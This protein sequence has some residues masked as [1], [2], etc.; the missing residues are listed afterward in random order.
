MSIDDG[1][2][3]GAA[4]ARRV[5]L[6]RWLSSVLL[7]LAGS[8]ATALHALEEGAATRTVET[9]HAALA[10]NIADGAAL[11]LE[12]RLAR[13]EPVLAEVFDFQTIAMVALGDAYA[14]LD[15]SQQARFRALLERQSALT[16]ADNFKSTQHSPRFVT[17]AEQPARGAR[18]VVRTR[19]ERDDGAPVS[20][21]YVVHDTPRGPRVV[22]VLAEGVSDLSLKRAQYA[23]VIRRDGV[24]ALL[25][26]IEK[27]VTELAHTAAGSG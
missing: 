19:L 21:D 3:P 20:L 26:Q 16:Y 11:G 5:R 10:R 25:E 2:A 1:A 6:R 23:A 14:R 18:V 8:A 17:L 13:I 22:N 24:D 12:G 15:A 27:Q 9:L 4:G 7:V